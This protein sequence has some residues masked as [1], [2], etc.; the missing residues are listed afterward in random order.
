[1]SGSDDSKAKTKTKKGKE[2]KNRACPGNKMVF[3]FPDMSGFDFWYHWQ[4]STFYNP[5][6]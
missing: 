6:H 1:L 2:E 5:S 4:G 3:H